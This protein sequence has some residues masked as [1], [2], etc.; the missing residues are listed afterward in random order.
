[1]DLATFSSMLTFVALKTPGKRGHL[2]L[3]RRWGPFLG[4][5]LGAVLI[6]VDLTRHVCL[7]AGMAGE[8]WNMFEEDGSLTPAGRVGFWATWIGNALLLISLVCYV[9]PARRA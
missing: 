5:L 4:L 6:M 1:M 9:L 7:D 3:L 2:P 8:N